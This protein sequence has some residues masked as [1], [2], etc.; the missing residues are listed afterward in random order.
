M[1][2][3]FQ[4]EPCDFF[5]SGCMFY[6]CEFSPTLSI[7]HWDGLKPVFLYRLEKVISLKS[8]YAK[9]EG[10][11]QVDKIIKISYKGDRC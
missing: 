9:A 8:V 6:V 4:L 11:Y 2:L 5:L 1:L 10:L 7:D 3:F